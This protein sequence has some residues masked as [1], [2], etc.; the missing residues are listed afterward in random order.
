MNKQ[1]ASTVRGHRYRILGLW[2]RGSTV[3]FPVNAATI[4]ELKIVDTSGKNKTIEVCPG[5]P[6][7][8]GSFTAI[9]T[10]TPPATSL[11]SVA[12]DRCLVYTVTGAGDIRIPCDIPSLPKPGRD[13]RRLLPVPFVAGKTFAI[14]ILLMRHWKLR[15]T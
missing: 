6:G 9:P 1:M 11:K 3:N 5:C 12:R 14:D 4:D 8:A 7:D 10:S 13:H 15:I 2:S